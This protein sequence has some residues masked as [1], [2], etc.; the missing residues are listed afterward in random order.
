MQGSDDM[1]PTPLA[2]ARARQE[3][4]VATMHALT[5]MEYALAREAFHVGSALRRAGIVFDP[6]TFVALRVLEASLA[7]LADPSCALDV[8]VGNGSLGRSIELAADLL[9]RDAA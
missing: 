1:E 9:A 2:A 8:L 3:R 7:E 6:A 5:S 4:E